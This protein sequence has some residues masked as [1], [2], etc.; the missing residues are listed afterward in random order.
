MLLKVG[1]NVQWTSQSA[2]TVLTKIG[3]VIEVVPMGR[4]V[5]FSTAQR[6]ANVGCRL[7][8]GGGYPR[9]HESYLVKVEQGKRKP[10]VYW[11][12]VSALEKLNHG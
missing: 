11:P 6:Y 3:K 4:A 8:N 5:D 12:R 7:V 9:N 10:L 2:G 1:D